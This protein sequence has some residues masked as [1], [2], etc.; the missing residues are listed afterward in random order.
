MKRVKIAVTLLLTVLMLLT[1]TGCG[2][3]PI[4]GVWQCELDFEDYFVE[5]MDAEVKDELASVGISLSFEDYISDVA[6][7]YTAEFKEDGT[8]SM[9][10]DEDDVADMVDSFKASTSEYCTD[11]IK[12]ICVAIAASTGVQCTEDTVEETMGMTVDEMA[13][14]VLG[15]D[16]AAY[17]DSCYGDELDANSLADEMYSEG[18]Y[19]TDGDKILLS[20]GL[21]YAVDPKYYDYYSIEGDSLTISYGTS[22]LGDDSEMLSEMLKNMYP[23]TFDRVQ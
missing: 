17:V 8:Y 20:A 21:D 4:V 16:I 14:D 13:I 23:L 2:K 15:M 6:F 7:E 22:D 11:L 3:N 5:M 18:R 9:T 12:K 10:A 19:K 1:L